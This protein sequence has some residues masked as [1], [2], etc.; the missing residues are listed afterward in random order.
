M[1]RLLSALCCAVMICTLPGCAGA[2]HRTELL[3][4]SAQIVWNSSGK[5]SSSEKS[6]SEESSE[7]S[8]EAGSSAPAGESSSS[9]P[10]SGVTSSEPVSSEPV[11]SEP[12]SSEPSSSE[13]SS[14]E[15]ASGKVS[16]GTASS[17]ESVS[18][19]SAVSPSGEVR[20]VWFSYLDLSGMVKNQTASSF[21]SAIGAA[22][23]NVAN[24]G[25]NTVFVQVRPFGDALYESDYFPWSYLLTGTEGV[26]PGY[27]PLAIM[28]EEAHSRGLSIV[29]WINPYRVRNANN[30]S[31]GLS[32]GNQA[33]VWLKA[34]SEA[35]VEYAGGIYYNP[36]SDDARE[37]IVAGVREI[38]ENYAV[39]GIHFDDY[40][41]P[42]TDSAFD[43]AT[44]QAYR[45]GGGSLSL[46]DWRR[47]NVDEL[48][49]EVYAAIKGIDSSVCFGISPQGN[50]SINYDE[51]YIDVEEWLSNPGYVDYICP[52]VYYGFENDTCPFSAT[53]A[54]WNSLIR[55]S[56]IEL[57]IGISASKI[58]LTDQWA[59]SGSEEWVE[60]DDMLARMVSQARGSSHYGGF[61]M[62]SYRSLY[63]PDAGVADQVEREKDALAEI[64]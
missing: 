8:S 26:D 25:Y 15:S 11:S 51:Q 34:G 22:F 4:S 42:S 10:V 50:T 14:S 12:V 59:G 60:N 43:S 38:V 21:R 37:L 35:V 18:R 48:V 44:Y 30:M 13:P 63:A 6:S 28:V 20:A 54:E 52:Q 31:H 24:D 57:Y 36:G 23:S 3:S 2:D 55:Q 39:D 1:K 47:A 5:E 9:G 46:G 58:G 40:F 64:L 27:D 29:A 32:A 19:P 45:S 33:S 62:Y 7:L 41:Y 49:R 61:C 56:G 53:V 16:S 17:E